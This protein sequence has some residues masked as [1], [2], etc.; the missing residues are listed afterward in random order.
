MEG[1]VSYLKCQKKGKK[2]VDFEVGN[3]YLLLHEEK[4][5][6]TEKGNFCTHATLWPYSKIYRK[7]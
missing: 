6:T 4:D 2:Q 7:S 1:V 5:A 3:I